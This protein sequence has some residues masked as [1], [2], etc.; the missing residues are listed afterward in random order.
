M[1][2]VIVGLHKITEN[3]RHCFLFEISTKTMSTTK[4]TFFSLRR[5]LKRKQ[6]QKNVFLLQFKIKVPEKNTK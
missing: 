2:K 1:I 3:A 5:N 4:F 6:S